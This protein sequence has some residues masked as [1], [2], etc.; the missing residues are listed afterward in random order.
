[1]RPEARC[2]TNNSRPNILFEELLKDNNIEFEREFPIEKYSYDFKIDNKLVEINPST[3]HNS[4]W[5]LFN[6]PKDKYYHFNKS[7]TARDNNYTCIHI[8]DWDDQ[9][10]IIKL[11]N[12]NQSRIYARKCEIREASKKDCDIFLN[13]YHLQGTCNNQSI[14]LGLYYNDSL[15]SIMTFGKPRYNRKYEY[16]LLR[17]CSNSKVIGGSNKLFS[18]FIENNNP[19]S[20]ISYCD[21]SKFSG[22]L[23]KKLG[24]DL[25]S[26]GISKHWYNIKTKQHVTDNLLRQRGFDQL[27]GTNYGNGTSNE[28]L[29]LGNGFVEIYD[30]GQAS[31]VYKG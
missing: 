19:K 11:L 4:S 8:F 14:R 3:T 22:E 27:F 26:T 6:N 1:M 21:L 17:Y 20:I 28:E 2:F 13:K 16:E 5:G 7:K 23:Y 12:S 31:Y 25:L 29:M 10:K 18:Y 9:S 24:F 30:A 15:V